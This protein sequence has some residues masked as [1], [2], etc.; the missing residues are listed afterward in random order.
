[1]RSVQSRRSG[2]V[3]C[4]YSQRVRSRHTAAMAQLVAGSALVASLAIAVVAVCIGIA[5][6]APAHLGEGAASAAVATFLA[7]VT[8]GLVGLAAFALHERRARRS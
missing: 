5:A 1:M 2:F 3:P 8:V 7:V 4:S 6:A